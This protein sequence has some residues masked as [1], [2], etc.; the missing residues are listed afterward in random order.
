MNPPTII[1][2]VL[3]A[4]VSILKRLTCALIFLLPILEMSLGLLVSSK[5][6]DGERS[7]CRECPG[8]SPASLGLVSRLGRGWSWHEGYASGPA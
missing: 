4:F 8:E 2:S 3:A 6:G 5:V 7:L 1:P